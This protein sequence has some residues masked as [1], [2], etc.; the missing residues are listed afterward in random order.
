MVKAEAVGWG[1]SLQQWRLQPAV[2]VTQSLALA[3]MVTPPEQRHSLHRQQRTQV[4]AC[5]EQSNYDVTM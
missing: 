5:F 3:V 2:M 1:M 4:Q